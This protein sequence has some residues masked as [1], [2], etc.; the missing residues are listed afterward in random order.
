[1]TE[2]A[3]RIVLAS[4]PV[5]EPTLDNFRL[6]EVPIPQPGPDQMLLRTLWLSL[7][8]Y[9]RGRMSDAPSY[10]KPVVIGDVMEGGTVSEVVTS[11]VHRFA[12]GDIVVGRTGWQSHALSDGSSLQKVDP[13]RA[14]IQTALG[15]L[16][17]PGMTAYM[18]LLEI[19]KPAAGETVVVA[20]A[21]GAVG[22]VVGQIARIKGASAVGI[23][24]GPDKCR[25]VTEEL[26][27]D[28]CI[29]HRAPDLAARLAA[30]C[31]KGIDIYFENVGGA[32]FETVCPLLNPFGVR[33]DLHVQRHLAVTWPDPPAALDASDLDQTVDVSRFH[34][35]RLFRALWGFHAR[36]L[37]LGRR[38]TN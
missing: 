8:P 30:A 1:M 13:T 2:T 6:E 33:A 5:G 11:N 22:S 7:D 23:A 15:V 18:G 27:F 36:C 28:A 34:R 37:R 3:E 12:K 21:S 25:Y 9:M 31:P 19:G 20:A 32:V 35:L 4:R 26:G 29:D 16:G 17:M 14:P 38:G 24:G 10:A